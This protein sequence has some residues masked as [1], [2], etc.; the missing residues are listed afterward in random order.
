[1]TKGMLSL[2]RFTVI[3]ALMLTLYALT[4]SS[5]PKVLA[6]CVIQGT[7]F[8]DYNADGV[9]DAN[10]PG[11]PNITVNA[12]DAT[13]V[14]VVT[15]T[16]T[17]NGTYTLDLSALPDQEVRVEFENIPTYLRPGPSTPLSTTFSN[18][19]LRT[20]VT[21]VACDTGA[22]IPNVNL[23]LANPGQHCGTLN[24]DLTT[25]CYV[26]GDNI[27]G[28]NRLNDVLVSFPYTA[29]GLNPALEVPE[30]NAADIGTTF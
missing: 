27:N 14:I 28:P 11:V 17:A 24:P 25:N 1:M 26:F 3:A 7:V 5:Q 15:A 29:T 6:A 18:T 9:F 13:N 2:F 20:T 30:A 21:F 4:A 23:G 10:E 8:R 12:F 16:T 19:G 22:P